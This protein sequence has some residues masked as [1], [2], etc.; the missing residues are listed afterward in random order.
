MSKEG[1]HMSSGEQAKLDVRYY[2]EL[3]KEYK[4]FFEKA[5]NAGSG[6]DL[7]SEDYP[8]ENFIFDLDAARKRIAKK[9]LNRK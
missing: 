3:Q 6:F 2:Q 7:F 4:R 1:V 9:M 5:S 8:A